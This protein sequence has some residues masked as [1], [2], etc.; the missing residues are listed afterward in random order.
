MDPL[1]GSVIGRKIH[2]NTR[3]LSGSPGGTVAILADTSSWDKALL[4][5][6][7]ALEQKACD[8]VVMNV[9]E[10]TSI[11]DYFV[12]CSGRSDRQGQS[13][14][15]GLEENSAEPGTKPLAGE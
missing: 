15:Q 4:L 5:T 1:P 8:L 7:L 11:A 14:A 6:R 3:A 13:I 2:Q 10:I 9:R 12:I